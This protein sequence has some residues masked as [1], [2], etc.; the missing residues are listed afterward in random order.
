[1]GNSK[2]LGAERIVKHF[3]GVKALDDVSLSI[4]Q[5]EVLGLIGPNGAGKTT[6]FNIISGF[7]KPDG[8]KVIFKG[9]DI[10]SHPPH[11]IARMGMSRTFQNL[12]VF[13]EMSVIE[14]IMVG[15]DVL[16]SAG[17]F[18]NLFAFPSIWK[19]ERE[20]IEKAEYFLEEVGLQDFR[21]TPA[22]DLPFGKMRLVELARALVT[23]PE[24][25]LLDEIASGLNTSE[26]LDLMELLFKVKEKHN[27]T[28][29]VVEHDMDFLMNLAERVVVLNFG[30]VIAEGSPDE[31]KKD[32]QVIAAYLGE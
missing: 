19:S 2:I 26:T 30:R 14:N 11:K 21:N 20:S 3:G 31:I 8:G 32:P 27:L 6:L 16:T 29:L 18:S 10:T 15:A 13:S 12:R 22:G 1:M 5:E 28:I 23:E 4:S 7:I 24:L 9:V 25:L 17:F